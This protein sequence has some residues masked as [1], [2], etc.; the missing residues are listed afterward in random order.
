MISHNIYGLSLVLIPLCKGRLRILSVRAIRYR[1]ILSG[2]CRRI[3]GWIIRLAGRRGVVLATVR[4]GCGRTVKGI[5]FLMC[6]RCRFWQP[7][8]HLYC[9]IFS[10]HSSYFS[11]HSITT[12][13]FYPKSISHFKLKAIQKQ[14][15]VA[16]QAEAT[17]FPAVLNFYD[18]IMYLI[19]FTT[20]Q[21]Y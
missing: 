11:Y 18:F 5:V 4:I 8:C 10:H 9:G 13:N 6:S 15:A 14:E 1:S 7:V 19:L 12:L 16:I 20:I 17:V 21:S 3:T 2:I